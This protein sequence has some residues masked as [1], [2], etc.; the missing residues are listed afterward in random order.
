MLVLILLAWACGLVESFS[1]GTT[2][3]APPMHASGRSHSRDSVQ[4]QTDRGALHI[5]SS[6]PILGFLI[7]GKELMFTDI[8]ANAKLTDVCGGNE[9]AVSHSN[10]TPRDS[11]EVRYR[12]KDGVDSAELTI[13]VVFGYKIPHVSL[14]GSVVCPEPENPEPLPAVSESPT[15]PSD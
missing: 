1:R 15:P 14:S 9:S 4:V 12:C 13:Y 2:Q 10:S 8:P 7:Y 5:A 11:I 6:R 3:C